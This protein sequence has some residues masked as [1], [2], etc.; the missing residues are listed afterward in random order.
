MMENHNK[1]NN[2]FYGILIFGLLLLTWI[3]FSGQMDGFHLTLGVISCLLVTWLSGDL[4]FRDRRIGLMNRLVQARRMISYLAWLLY[5]IVLANLHLIRLTFSREITLQPQ[6]VRYQSNLK[7]DFEKFLLAN[8][9]TLTPGTITM[10]IMD[11]TFY[12]HAVS[13]LAARSLDGE[14]ERRIAKV[15]EPCHQ[16]AST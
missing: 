7:T 12:I 3:V 16:S 4:V 8:S 1:E 10:K 5:Q 14:M 13:D 6:I 11:N 15:F 2:P 9:I